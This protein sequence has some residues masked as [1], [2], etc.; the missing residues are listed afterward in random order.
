MHLP[1]YALQTILNPAPVTNYEQPPFTPP[2][3]PTIA[4]EPIR[5]N[6]FGLRKTFAA[7][8]RFS[9]PEAES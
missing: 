2:R 1:Y 6:P 9:Q 8:N 3:L 4:A 7:F 5:T